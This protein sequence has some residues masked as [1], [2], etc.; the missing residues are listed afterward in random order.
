MTTH[1]SKNSPV[2]T[3]RGDTIAAIAT[4]SGRGGI[5][6][7][8]VSGPDSFKI[9]RKIT[10]REPTARTAHFCK[11]YNSS[12]E[13][14]DRGILIYFPS[15][16]S[17]TGEDVIEFQGHGGPVVMGMLLKA[18]LTA[19]ARPAE[20]GEFT[21]RAFFNDKIDLLQA[22][23]VA[24]LIN[25]VSE[26][27]ARSAA[28]SLQGEFSRHISILQGDLTSLRVFIESTMDFPEEEI[29]FIVDSDV[30]DRLNRLLKNLSSLLDLA[31]TGSRLRE[32]LRVAII[33]R[34]NVGKS[35]LLNRLT[36][37]DR[38]IVTEVAGTT[39][40]IIEDNITVGGINLNIVDTAGLREAEGIVEEEGIRRSI[41]EISRADIVIL[42]TDL[43][44]FGD[45]DQAILQE[46]KITNDKLI[47][48]HNKADLYSDLPNGSQKDNMI[49]IYLSAKTGEGTG[50]LKD[51]LLTLAG[52]GNTGDDVVLARE[53]HINAISSARKLIEES[54]REF[55]QTPRAELLAESLRMA[56]TELSRVTG[57]VTPDDLLSEIFS[58]FCIGK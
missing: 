10:H 17:Y 21:E 49:H 30:T 9:A 32:G 6:V 33:G 48:V 51:N 53:R 24:D 50:K 25:S 26:Q 55:T 3:G 56:Q 23:A 45:Q 38:A 39:R 58:K 1:Q 16:G 31:Q 13:E 40:D 14:I 29:D 52:I 47:I 11:F 15:P 28:R 2:Q 34:P 5:G 54:T 8:R 7:I 35:S 18:V 12:D 22:E 36:G 19:G 43:P 20:P 44:V 46:N 41:C 42:V 37:E 57:E 4:P 27:A